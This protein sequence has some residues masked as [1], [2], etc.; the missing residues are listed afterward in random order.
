MGLNVGYTIIYTT[1]YIG[2]IKCIM[3]YYLRC[4][5][6]FLFHLAAAL[7]SNLGNI[8]D[9]DTTH[10]FNTIRAQPQRCETR[11]RFKILNLTKTCKTNMPFLQHQSSYPGKQCIF[12][13]SIPQHRNIAFYLKPSPQEHIK[14]CAHL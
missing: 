4:S 13:K 8:A 11:I 1:F 12:P 10:L 6:L 3:N 5:V 2:Y 9:T 14:T 7:N